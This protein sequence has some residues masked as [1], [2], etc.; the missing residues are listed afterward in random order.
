MRLFERAALLAQLRDSPRKTKTFLRDQRCVSRFG[1]DSSSPFKLGPLCVDM[2]DGAGD[3][4][5]GVLPS[6]PKA[7]REEEP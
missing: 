2:R 6:P 1:L 3:F 7:R 4:P 5:W